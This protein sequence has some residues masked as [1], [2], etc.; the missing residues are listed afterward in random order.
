[1]N[2][3]RVTIGVLLLGLLVISGCQKLDDLTKF[4]MNYNVAIVIPSQIGINIPLVIASPET[5][6]NFEDSLSI[7]DSRKNLVESVKLKKMSLVITDPSGKSFSFMK[8]VSILISA[9]GLAE[10][11]I[12]Y[13][14]DIDNSAGGSIDLL[15]NDVELKD[16]LLKD[17]FAL[18]ANTITDE[19]ITQNVTID[20]QSRFLVDAK[21]L[22]I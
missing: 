7:K 20:I 4:D 12:A 17:K 5:N 8:S 2:I 1:M 6:T 14:T 13:K 10:K 18:K 11:E 22:G 9:Q 3:S 21:I 19:I 16:Y 15:L